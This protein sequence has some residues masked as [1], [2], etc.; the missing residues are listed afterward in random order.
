MSLFPL[1]ELMI[2]TAP[3]TPEEVVDLNRVV[4]VLFEQARQQA[5]SSQATKSDL[6]SFS[7][8]PAPIKPPLKEEDS[9]GR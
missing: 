6:G 5:L 3:T 4:E 1:Q 2:A 7:S 8:Q 9:S